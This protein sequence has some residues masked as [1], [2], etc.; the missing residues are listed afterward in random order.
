MTFLEA[1]KGL[2]SLIA[3]AVGVMILYVIM[4]GGWTLLL[5]S[6]KAALQFMR[7]LFRNP[8]QAMVDAPFLIQLL[9]LPFL[10]LHERIDKL[11]HLEEARRKAALF[12][13]N[14]KAAQVFQSQLDKLALYREGR[15]ITLCKIVGFEV[16]EHLARF[17]AEP[18]PHAGF[19]VITEP[20]HF[21]INWNDFFY[22]EKCLAADN[23]FLHWRVNFD[24][25]RIRSLGVYAATLSPELDSH[26]R[27]AKLNH[28]FIYDMDA[29]ALAQKRQAVQQ[30]LTGLKVYIN[31][32]Q[33]AGDGGEWLKE[34][35]EALA[36]EVN[37]MSV[38]AFP[39]GPDDLS[40]TRFE[41]RHGNVVMWVPI[42]PNPW[43]IQFSEDSLLRWWAAQPT[44]PQTPKPHSN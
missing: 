44:L 17:D 27:Y 31:A 32:A 3:L 18:V 21:S 42:L 6:V 33:T 38:Y 22:D 5:R 16:S 30:A 29:D 15:T 14:Q 23:Q 2:G 8:R 7:G 13:R 35:P 26:E 11:R 20:W 37:I 43:R 41:E 4:K 24:E 9:L 36:A 1:L 25:E 10:L 28:F 19:S 39:G 34:L 12:K 40:E